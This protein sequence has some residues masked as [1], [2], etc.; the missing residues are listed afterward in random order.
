[1]NKKAIITVLFALVTMAGQAQ[2]TVVW[3]KPVIGC[4]QYNYID[5]QKVELAKDRTSL[6]MQITHPSNDWF[7]FSP[8]SYIEADGKHYE[9]VGSDGIK[10]GAEEYTSPNT[11][12]RNF[13]LHFKPIPQ[14]TKMFDMLESTQRGD[15]TF[16][17]IHPSDY[18]VPETPVPLDFRADYP[19]EDIWPEYVFS[20]EP[21]TVHVKALNYKKGMNAGIRISYFDITN[22]NSMFQSHIFLDDEGC[23]DFS[24]KVYY[25]THLQFSMSSAGG[26]STASPQV[27]PGKEVT[28]LYDMLRN[29]EYPNTKVIGYKGYLAKF[30]KEKDEFPIRYINNGKFKFPKSYKQ[31][32]TVG[33]IIAL[34]DS[35]M[36]AFAKALSDIQDVSDIVKQHYLDWELRSFYVI[37]NY[38]D[39]LFSTQEFRDYIFRTRP[40]CFYDNSVRI[41]FDL[42]K[43]A[44][45]FAGTEEKGF[46]PDL[47]RFIHS[48]S[49]LNSG[50][51]NPK[52]LLDDPNLSRFYDQRRQELAATINKKKNELATNIHYMELSDVTPENT[53]QFL[54]DR[55]KGM[56]VFIDLWA[57]WCAPCRQGHQEMKPVKEELRDKNI[58]YLYITSST[59][60]YEEWKEMI[61]TIPGEHY[62]LSP[63]QFEALGR[64]YQSGGGI[65]VYAIYNSKG[66][67]VHNSIG[68]AIV[69]P[70]KTGLM[71]AL[72]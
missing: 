21:A 51:F 35:L 57:T 43:M 2:K 23:A 19:E 24:C 45:L 28:I 63:E 22:P 58:V 52:P 6:Y 65:P 32:K 4:S 20:E 54:L 46:G 41:D 15:F 29:D 60:P 50:I 5:I 38:C 64:L 59:S 40:K 34:H 68:F 12:K 3:E 36:T 30:D 18:V 53:L 7:R 27:A 9:I 31:Y 69:D 70:L 25:P 55:Y 14:N 26:T 8:Q 47:L 42:R 1:M 37:A 13:V 44:K 16:F 11:R 39:S 17:Y 72:E 67:L 49:E 33:D 48:M 66:E 61:K 62:Y 10:L 71:K 56:T